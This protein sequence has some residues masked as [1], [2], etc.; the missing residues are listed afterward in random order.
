MLVG[1]FEASS[2]YFFLKF[3]LFRVSESKQ[4]IGFFLEIKHRSGVLVQLAFMIE[5]SDEGGS[6]SFLSQSH[7]VIFFS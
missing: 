5:M 1:I 7:C 6:T 4:G 2:S 3:S